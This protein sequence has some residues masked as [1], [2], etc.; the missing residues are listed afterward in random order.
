MGTFS[1]WAMMNK[2]YAD[3]DWFQDRAGSVTESVT[4]YL[5]GD[6]H[7]FATSN[8]NPLTENTTVNRSHIIKDTG[9]YARLGAKVNNAHWMSH[10]WGDPRMTH[11]EWEDKF[12]RTRMP[13][14]YGFEAQ[15]RW[16]VDGNNRTGAYTYISQVWMRFYKPQT[17]YQNN[18]NWAEYDFKLSLT[19][20]SESNPVLDPTYP[21]QNGAKRSDDW[22]SCKWEISANAKAFI[23]T[24][25]VYLKSIMI[26]QEFEKMSG[27]GK[28]KR[29]MD[30]R[31]LNLMF[32][33]NT[34]EKPIIYQPEQRAWFLDKNYDLPYSPFLI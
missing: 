22:K 12:K 34:T 16:P 21:T 3:Y 28:E 24:Q 14:V 19:D 5:S 6:T 26:Q 15:Y 20:F 18:T 33:Q 2:P 7:N 11:P 1:T 30:W 32:A 4:D 9:G 13:R 23:L 29:A 10:A 25:N 31:K 8:I 27:V 17:G